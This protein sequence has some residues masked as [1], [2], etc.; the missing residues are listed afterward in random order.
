MAVD[1]GSPDQLA[2]GPGTFDIVGVKLGMPV[3]EALKVLKAYNPKIQIGP[4]SGAFEILPDLE[5]TAGYVADEVLKSNG[6]YDRYPTAPERFLLLTTTAPSKAYVWAIAR[7]I[8]Y[9]AANNQPLASNFVESLKKKY[10]PPSLDKSSI[11]GSDLSWSLGQD[12]K[13]YAMRKKGI[14]LWAENTSQFEQMATQMF[15]DVSND[16]SRGV[17]HG[18]AP[19]QYTAKNTASP[20]CGDAAELRVLFVADRQGRLSSVTMGA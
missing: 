13:P 2:S 10:G 5:I 16:I 12:G 7:Y 4:Q 14:C 3:D 8:T 9:D 6:T 1:F 20:A 17:P 18:Q 15:N 11:Y 19:D